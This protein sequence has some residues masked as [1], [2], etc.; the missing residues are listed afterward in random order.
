MIY[1]PLLTSSKETV[2]AEPL[3]D[4]I[5]G[6]A[7]NEQV[8]L[9]DVRDQVIVDDGPALTIAEEGTSVSVAE[10]GTSVTVQD[11]VVQVVVD[12]EQVTVVAA[13]EVGPPGPPGP[14]G[15]P[16]NPYTAVAPVE[17]DLQA[18]TI[19]LT[20]GTLDG[21]GMLWNGTAWVS[22][23][24]VPAGADGTIPY[25]VGQGMGSDDTN[26][27]YDPSQ[28][29]LRVTKLDTALLDGGNF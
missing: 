19:Q 8:L 25:K 11:E 12:A 20:P 15:A 7:P 17:V 13:G 6:E 18:L 9:A 28:Q 29:A 24:V 16:G 22:Q 26:F 14:A 10:D 4:S 2:S 3:A 21:Q 23:T 27:R 1:D 5:V